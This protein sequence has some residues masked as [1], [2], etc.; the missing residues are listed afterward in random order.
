[1]MHDAYSVKWILPCFVLFLVTNS[2]YF[3]IYLYGEVFLVEK[4][5]ILCALGTKFFY[6][7]KWNANF[8]NAGD[9]AFKHSLHEQQKYTCP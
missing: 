4:Y 5:S 3:A 7:I 6:K 2:H 8:Q 1:M 9:A